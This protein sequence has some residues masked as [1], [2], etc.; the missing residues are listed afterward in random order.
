[1]KYILMSTALCTSSTLLLFL[2]LKIAQ[3]ASIAVLARVSLVTVLLPVMD[4]SYFMSL[5]GIV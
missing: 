4:L 2:L 1:M 5:G 3:S